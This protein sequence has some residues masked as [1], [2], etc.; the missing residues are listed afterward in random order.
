MKQAELAALLNVTPQAVS[1]WELGISYPDIAM[2]PGISE[3]LSVTSDEL[4]GIRR[5]DGAEDVKTD[6][7]LKQCREDSVLNQSQVDSIFDYVPEAISAKS[8]R[9]LLVDDSDFLR[10]L[11]KDILEARGHE[12]LP[13]KDGQEGLDILKDEAVD[14]CLLDIMMPGM[15]GLEALKRIKAEYPGIRVVM[16][17]AMSTQKVVEQTLRLGADAFVAKPFQESCLIERLG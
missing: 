13:A 15:D 8:K 16:L 11:L 4:L 14:V 3:V 6:E 1:R 5:P 12:V 10:G 7:P 9:I 17:S 2:I